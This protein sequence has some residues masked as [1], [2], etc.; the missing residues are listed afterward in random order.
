MKRSTLFLT[1]CAVLLTY[2]S[3]SFAHEGHEHIPVSMKKAVE[4]ALATAAQYSRETPPF[5]IPQLDDS[6]RALPNSAAKI[7]EN[8]RGYYVVSVENSDAAKTLYL[9]ILL[10]GTI[11]NA[12][13]SGEF[14]PAH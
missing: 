13:F 14:P 5:K 2:S 6:W 8:G 9:R 11:E 4:L 3:F 12:N 1:L 10:D 7:H